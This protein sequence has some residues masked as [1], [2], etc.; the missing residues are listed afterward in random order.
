MENNKR[1][2]LIDWTDEGFDELERSVCVFQKKISYDIFDLEELEEFI[3]CKMSGC[4]KLTCNLKLFDD[5]FQLNFNEKHF[6]IEELKASDKEIKTLNE[7]RQPDLCGTKWSLEFIKSAE[8]TYVVCMFAY[9][10]NN[11]NIKYIKPEYL[12][13]DMCREAI[14]NKVSLKNIPQKYQDYHMCLL[15]VKV[16]SYNIRYVP[17]KHFI[18]ELSLIAVKRNGCVLE[19]VKCRYIDFEMCLEAMLSSYTRDDAQIFT[20][21][22]IPQ[23]YK[24]RILDKLHEIADIL[25]E[26]AD[27]DI[28]IRVQVKNTDY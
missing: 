14:E 24:K 23:M 27:K 4:N 19:F 3:L 17:S 10:Q 22:F 16:Y 8:K 7:I 25:Y 12:T 11:E 21:R 13:Y 6:Y 5:T 9:R 26:I 15:A 18:R 2:F 28:D 1:L 20:W